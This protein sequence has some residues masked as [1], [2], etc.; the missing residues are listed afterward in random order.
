M[1]TL[2]AERSLLE[3]VES[4]GEPGT[5]PFGFPPGGSSRVAPWGPVWVRVRDDPGGTAGGPR[6]GPLGFT[7]GVLVR[8]GLS[9][10][11]EPPG[12]VGWFVF[13]GESPPG[14]YPP[15]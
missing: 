5:S 12:G 7:F 11:V 13:S 4:P 2:L 14:L 3:L 9:S 8:G 1:R 6:R 15:G 10:G